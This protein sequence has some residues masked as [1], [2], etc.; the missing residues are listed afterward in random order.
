MALQEGAH[1]F[2]RENARVLS[3]VVIAAL[4]TGSEAVILLDQVPDFPTNERY[5]YLQMIYFF[6]WLGVL[7]LLAYLARRTRARIVTLYLF[8]SGLTALGVGWL[9]GIL[10]V[11]VGIVASI[12]TFAVGGLLV[13][14]PIRIPMSLPNHRVLFIAGGFATAYLYIYL[15]F[16]VSLSGIQ[17]E[18]FQFSLCLLAMTA[19]FVATAKAFRSET[20]GDPPGIS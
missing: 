18:N 17:T 4:L 14:S 5:A 15:L 2:I 3:I 9:T 1:Q 8:I 10:T 19:I 7:P 13:F 16:I 12:V 6:S 11:D 20:W